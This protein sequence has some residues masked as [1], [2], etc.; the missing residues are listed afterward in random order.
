GRGPGRARPAQ[1]ARR[2]PGRRG[3]QGP[4]DGD[5]GPDHQGPRAGPR[6]RVPPRHPRVPAPPRAAGDHKGQPTVILA[7]TIKGRG[8][9]REFESRNATHQMK[10]FVRGTL[11]TFRDRLGIDVPDEALEKGYPPYYR[12]PEDSD[13]H[14]YLLERRG[15]LGGP[16]P[17]RVDRSHP[18]DLPARELYGQLKKGSGKQEVATTMALVR[19]IRDLLRNKDVGQRIVPIIP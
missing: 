7:Q 3:P 10:K 11:N 13:L 12:P 19:L 14:K 4:A 1:G 18:L 15:E 17:A 5:P 16:V 6:V 9:G 8:L 2:L